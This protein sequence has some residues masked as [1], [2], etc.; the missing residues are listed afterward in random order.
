MES[1]NPRERG[2]LGPRGLGIPL[3]GN[4]KTS[5]TTK[6]DTIAHLDIIR[7]WKN[8]EYR[9]SLRGAE[10]AMLP[11]HPAGL[12]ELRDIGWRL[13]TWSLI[14]TRTT[15]LEFTKENRHG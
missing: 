15:F 14:S 13:D 1:G 9:L 11:E 5:F 8:E 6:G 3:A 10:Q 4:D 12:I 2:L 7:A